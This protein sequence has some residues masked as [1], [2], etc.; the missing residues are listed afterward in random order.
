[1]SSQHTPVGDLPTREP[2]GFPTF[3]GP[4]PHCGEPVSSD[5]DDPN[6]A[7]IARYSRD[8]RTCERNVCPHCE[9]PISRVTPAGGLSLMSGQLHQASRAEQRRGSKWSKANDPTTDGWSRW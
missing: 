5:P 8:G 1:M 9:E 4:C 3:E 2:D 6:V 7:R